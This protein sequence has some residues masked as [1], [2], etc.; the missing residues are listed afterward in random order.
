MKFPYK[1]FLVQAIPGRSPSRAVFRPVIPIRLLDGSH[2]IA[3]EALIDSGAD[4]SI[5]HAE[6]G[7]A[8]GLDI[9]SGER[10]TYVGIGGVRKNG[11]RHS[12]VLELAGNRCGCEVV[13][14]YGLKMPYGILGQEAFFRRFKIAFDLGAGQIE[15]IARQKKRR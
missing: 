13:F 15:I 11:F 8:L 7:E 9:R 14:S 1:K 5:F 2:T 4:Y 6:I 12:V 10:M 3:Y